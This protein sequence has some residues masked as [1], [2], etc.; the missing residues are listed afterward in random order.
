M[1]PN[2]EAWSCIAGKC[3]SRLYTADF[4]TSVDALADVRRIVLSGA[5]AEFQKTG[6]LDDT[7]QRSAGLRAVHALLHRAHCKDGI[8]MD[9]WNNLVP[10][11]Q[12][13]DSVLIPRS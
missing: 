11:P 6:L 1:Q 3:F 10:K 7:P 9:T 4:V 8:D 2:C 5:E 13:L 12:V